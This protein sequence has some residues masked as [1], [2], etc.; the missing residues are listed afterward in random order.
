MSAEEVWKRNLIPPTDKNVLNALKENNLGRQG[1][2]V[3]FT[4]QL[5]QAEGPLFIS[6]DA[7]WGSGKT[8]F[9]QQVKHFIEDKNNVDIQDVGAKYGMK[10]ADREVI[11]NLIP[12]YYD[13]WRND[14]ETDPILSI[15]RVIMMAAESCVDQPVERNLY[16]GFEKVALLIGE[17]KT[18]VP[19]TKLSQFAKD[20]LAKENLLKSYLDAC[21]AQEELEQVIQKFCK[22]L[23]ISQCGAIKDQMKRENAA[24]QK[25]IVIFIDELDRCR[26]DFAVTLLERLK[27]YVNDDHVIFVM[28]TNLSELQHMICNFYGENFDAARYLDRFFDIRMVL[29]R[30]TVEQLWQILGEDEKK[31]DFLGLSRLDAVRY[32]NMSL[33]E[34]KRYMKWCQLA[35]PRDNFAGS[36]PEMQGWTFCKSYILPYMIAL[37]M[38]RPNQYQDFID[39][40]EIDGFLDFL[41]SL[42]QKVNLLNC[43]PAPRNAEIKSE[44]L[45]I[46]NYRDDIKELLAFLWKRSSRE[47]NNSTVTLDYHMFGNMIIR[48]DWR[49]KLC[50]CLTMM[51]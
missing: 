13:A 41:D 15:F 14:N 47:R 19:F 25:K 1:H 24:D 45:K 44:N 39:G 34:A 32:F 20:A 30:V 31:L 50:N 40:D 28:S 51:V 22:D 11:H 26:P 4:K 5:A 29:P 12:I 23:R 37:K 9:V 35:I 27:H 6:L 38:L 3:M 33:R 16:R 2:V 8:F 42:S 36:N 21:K 17:I 43:L 46:E 48:D 18:G 7:P 49:D 10:D